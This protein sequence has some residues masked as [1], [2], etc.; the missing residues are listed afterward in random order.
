M[1][2]LLKQQELY[3]SPKQGNFDVDQVLAAVRP[4]GFSLQDPVVPEL[5][6]IFNSEEQRAQ[7][8]AS[9][10]ANPDGPL[11][12]VLIIK[13]GPDE[14]LLNQFGGPAY[15]A[16]SRTFLTWLLAQYPCEAWNEEGTDLTGEL[17]Q[18]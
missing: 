6:M 14:I 16:H 8:A 17:G 11:P 10:Q 4:I 5:F 13:V 15:A 7:H 1:D 3:L 18:A 12:Y 9:L 2:K